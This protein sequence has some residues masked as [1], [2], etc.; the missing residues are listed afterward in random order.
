V[1]SIDCPRK[2]IEQTRRI[3]NVRY[4]ELRNNNSNS[5][6]SHH[7][8]NTGYTYGTIMDTMDIIKTGK[9]GRHLNTLENYYIYRISR[10][11]LHMKDTYIDTYNALFQT[12]H[13]LYARQQHTRPH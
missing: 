7:M 2:Y 8:L 4:K 5:V 11:N 1:K 13:E 3:F 6:Y 9:K 12:L 10:D